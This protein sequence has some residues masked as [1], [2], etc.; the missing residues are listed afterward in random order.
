MTMITDMNGTDS[1]QTNG[2]VASF[3]SSQ[4]L[5]HDYEAS[6][7]K[8]SCENS[9]NIHVKNARYVREISQ[10][11][12]SSICSEEIEAKQ[13]DGGLCWGCNIT[14]PSAY[15]HSRLAPGRT[16][17]VFLEMALKRLYARDDFDVLESLGEGFF[18]DVYKVQHRF[19]GEIMVLK[20]GKERERENRI[21]V[22]ANVLKEVDVLN[23]LTSHPNLLAFRGVCVDLSDKSWNLHI[24]MDFCDAGSLSRLIC[25]HQKH[26]RWSL[27]CSLARDISCAM[28]FVHSKGIMHR[29]L[30]SMNVLLQ[31]V[32]NGS[33]KAV[34]ADFGLSCR[35]PQTVE[36]LTQVGT[37]FWMA[38]ECLKEEF[39]DEKADVFS[40]GIILC[41]MI[42]RIDADPEAGLYRTHNFG[43]DYVR[44]TAHC[45]TDTP[46]DILNLTFQC[47]L[48]DPVARPSFVSVCNFFT[49]FRLS[50]HKDYKDYSE[51][52][53]RLVKNDGRLERSLSDATLK[54]WKSKQS[55]LFPCVL[56]QKEQNS[57]SQSEC[58][59]VNA[60]P[61][62]VLHEGVSYEDLS[63]TNRD[64]EIRN[65]S[66]MEEL[67]RSVAVDELTDEMSLDTG[68]PFIAHEIYKT[69]RKLAF[70]DRKYTVS[71]AKESDDINVNTTDYDNN[72]KDCSVFATHVSKKAASTKKFGQQTRI[73][74]IRR[75]ASLPN[76]LMNASW[77]RYSATFD[78]LLPSSSFT[79][80]MT[81]V[82]GQRGKADPIGE[83]CVLKGQMSMA[84]KNKDQKFTSR[85]CRS[86]FPDETLLS[87]SSAKNRRDKDFSLSL[88]DKILSHNINEL[89]F[90]HRKSN[91]NSFVQ[92]DNGVVI[93]QPFP[94]GLSVSKYSE[95]TF[96][97]RTSLLG[98]RISSNGLLSGMQRMWKV[99]YNRCHVQMVR[100]RT[101]HKGEVHDAT[102]LDPFCVAGLKCGPCNKQQITHEDDR[103]VPVDGDYC[104]VL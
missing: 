104:A 68:N 10:A 34:V 102:I 13:K 29:D 8:K 84:F 60:V 25:D 28:D 2:T 70:P 18:G 23:Q 78:P 58:R 15:K 65:K 1:L 82:V 73:S 77:I 4:T 38:P 19:T 6:V 97:N 35:I 83:H 80:L 64:D 24:L 96:V 37:P 53:S 57:E 43:L 46:L 56:T 99:D 89:T 5:L 12:C 49:N 86:T 79:S 95:G 48:M 14:D 44:F 98:T 71:D 74:K 91:F 20:V 3:S 33:L 69:T 100:N 62:L 9:D 39:Y 88:D 22:K 30:T 47:C 103:H 92:Q 42:A 59:L 26:F 55:K 94:V 81:T 21:R 93:Q 90:E 7:S 52:A 66:R 27:R 87:S 76:S 54:Y 41:Q 61:L 16:S 72:L 85:R 101:V 51:S 36:K 67:A 45:P 40:F 11:S 63:H 31:K 17:C 50:R 75:S 32:A